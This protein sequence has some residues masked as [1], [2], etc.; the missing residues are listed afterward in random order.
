MPWLTRPWPWLSVSSGDEQQAISI[1]VVRPWST[2]AMV[3]SVSSG[4]EQQAIIAVVRPWSTEAMVNGNE[5]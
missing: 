4:D 2:D 1:A 5:Q 3:N